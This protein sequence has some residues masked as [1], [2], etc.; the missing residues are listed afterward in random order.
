MILRIQK[1]K[2]F[3]TVGIT[4][5]ERAQPRPIY[6][7]IVLDYDHQQAVEEDNIA[8]A[9]DYSLI[10]NLVVSE[11]S[12]RQFNLIETMAVFLCQ[13]LL[14]QEKTRE[15]TVEV[16]KPGIMRFAENVSVIYSLRREE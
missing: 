1:I 8:H 13:L 14:G 15:V 2:A 3:S 6:I 16:E 12:Q 11:L 4:E 7:S 10:E 9:Y 5:E